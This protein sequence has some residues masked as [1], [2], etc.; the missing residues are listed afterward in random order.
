[1]KFIKGFVRRKIM[2]P[3]ILGLGLWSMTGCGTGKKLAE[4]PPAKPEN[5][6]VQKPD[7]Y[8]NHRLLYKTFTAKADARLITDDQN[9]KLSLKINM[10]KDQ[11][12]WASIIAMGVLEVARAYATPDSLFAINRLNKTAYALGYQQG[13]QLL[14]A[15]IPFSSLQDLFAGS[16]LLPADALVTGMEV[17]DSTVNITQ[18]KDSFIQ[19]L[20][21]DI[22]TQALTKL[23]L[24]ATNRPFQCSIDYSNY[25]KIGIGQS[26][27]YDRNIVIKND[28]K[29]TQLSINFTQANIDQPIT[30]NFMIPGSY[31][32]AH[33]VKKD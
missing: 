17:K 22:R 9:Q 33:E 31:H 29:E 19:V 23:Q 10:H 18:Q 32:V 21:Y 15:D 7:V 4:T 6:I 30:T 13:T 3:A 24:K 26:F 11:D 25:Q 5:A 16:P 20:Q 12:L 1:M 2:L 27:A 28:G 8:L 14:Q